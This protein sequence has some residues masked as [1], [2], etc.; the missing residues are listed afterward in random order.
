MIDYFK[1]QIA[2]N[3]SGQVTYFTRHP[4]KMVAMGYELHKH[5]TA[6]AILEDIVPSSGFQF[7]EMVED[8][9]IFERT[10]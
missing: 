3:P 6:V 2:R 4:N 8:Y 10:A 7:V 9:P 1:D 5:T